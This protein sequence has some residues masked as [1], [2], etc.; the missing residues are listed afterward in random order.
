MFNVAIE[1]AGHSVDQQVAIYRNFR[2]HLSPG[3]IYIIEDVQDLDATRHVFKTLDAG[4]RIE[5]LDLRCRK[6]RYDDVLV[7]VRD[8]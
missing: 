6:G 2:P 3:G 1:D 4:K 7:V 8:G 5:I